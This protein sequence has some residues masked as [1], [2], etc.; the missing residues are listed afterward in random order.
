MVAWEL[1]GRESGVLQKL[2]DKI[3]IFYPDFVTDDYAAYHQLILEN[4]L[5][6][7]KDLTFPIE[8]DNSNTRHYLAGFCLK[9]KVTSRSLEMVHLSLKLLYHFSSPDSLASYLKTI[10]STFA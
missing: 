7:G 3:G 9:P 5:F 4:Q 6:T 2:L 10:Q 1:G 8:Q